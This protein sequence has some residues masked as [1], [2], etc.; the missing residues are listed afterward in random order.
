MIA[1]LP[2]GETALEALQR[3][4]PAQHKRVTEAA[5]REAKRAY[6]IYCASKDG[7]MHELD[8]RTFAEFKKLESG[9]T[10]KP[11]EADFRQTDDPF[12]LGDPEREKRLRQAL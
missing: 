8:L 6:A 1:T 12:G 7:Q 11:R 2:E 9:E 10:W 3:C 5:E 4:N